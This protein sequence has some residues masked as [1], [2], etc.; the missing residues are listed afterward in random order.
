MTMAM[1]ASSTHRNLPIVASTSCSERPTTLTERSGKRVART[2]YRPEPVVLDTVNDTALSRLITVTL[3]ERLGIAPAGLHD[4][5][6]FVRPRKLVT[7]FARHGVTLT[8][9]GIRPS[10]TGLF[11]WL[12]LK[13]TPSGGRIL[14]TFSSAVLYQGTGRKAVT[15]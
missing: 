10:L 14:P 11:R 7:E 6:L 9:G 3:G 15:A 8:T 2:R 5:R 13:R 1:A 12:A 4:P